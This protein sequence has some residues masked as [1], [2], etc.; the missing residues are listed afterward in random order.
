M[1]ILLWFLYSTECY[2]C[3]RRLWQGLVEIHRLSNCQLTDWWSSD[4]R[5]TLTAPTIKRKTIENTPLVK[6]GARS[7]HPWYKGVMKKLYGNVR[8]NSKRI[9][10]YGMVTLENSPLLIHSLP[11][12]CRSWK[13]VSMFFPPPRSLRSVFND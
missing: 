7:L 12:L 6:R 11:V 2:C 13:V 1:Q 5:P 3:R 4:I 9:H 8:M 10:Q